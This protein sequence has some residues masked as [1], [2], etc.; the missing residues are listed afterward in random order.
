MAAVTA[1]T[2][3]L[4]V[5]AGLPVGRAVLVTAAVF[6]GQLTI[7]WSND[8]IDS[9]RDRLV[10]RADKPLA[11]GA[12]PART[13]RAALVAAL[14]ACVVLSLSC[15]WRSGLTHLVLG[16]GAGWAY[17]LGLKRTSWSWLPYAV[18]FG[19]LP[20]V[21][22]LALQPPRLPPWWLMA[23]GA[24]LGVGAHLVN[25]LPDLEDD[26][27][28]GVRGLPHRLGRH[29]C[30]LLATVVL[31]AA[32]SVVVLGP[33]T[34]PGGWSWTGLAVTAALAAVGLRWSGSVAFRATVAIAAVDVALLIAR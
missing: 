32:S 19:T 31:L 21:G 13:V 12:L 11:T 7:G 33:G 34:W 20:A 3:L 17:N 6:T 23:G 15:G 27:A 10:E 25:V 22:W 8:L 28:T 1:L 18:A 26:A 14:V 5:D 2:S 16:V 4:A 29:R 9:Q 30:Q 24:L